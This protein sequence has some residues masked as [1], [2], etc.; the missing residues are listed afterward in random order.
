MVGIKWEPAN[1][2]DVNQLANP[3]FAVVDAKQNSIN[4]ILLILTLL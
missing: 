4:D 2:W 3:F 1:R